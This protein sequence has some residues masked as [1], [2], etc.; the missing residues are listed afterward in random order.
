MSVIVRHDVR[1]KNQVAG[2]SVAYYSYR[3]SNPSKFDGW[4]C[5]VTLTELHQPSLFW[6]RGLKRMAALVSG[7]SSFA[8]AGLFVNFCKDAVTTH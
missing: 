8:Q 6:Q 4:E 2:L 5:A 3:Q 7:G 1:V